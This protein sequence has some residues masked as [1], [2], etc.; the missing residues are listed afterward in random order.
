MA[1]VPALFAAV[2]AAEGDVVLD[3][4]SGTALSVSAV[5][6][7]ETL[8]LASAS[9]SGIASISGLDQRRWLRASHT[10]TP[11]PQQGAP[12]APLPGSDAARGS[13]TSSAG[14]GSG[15]LAISIHNGDDQMEQ[16]AS[17]A[18]EYRALSGQSIDL[19]GFRSIRLLGNGGYQNYKAYAW[20]TATI[21]SAAGSAEFFFPN[22]WIGYGELEVDLW[23]GSGGP[24]DP[25][26]IYSIS[27]SA[28]GANI[29]YSA[30]DFNGAGG[31]FFNYTMSSIQL[32][33]PTPAALAVLGAAAFASRSRHR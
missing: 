3:D 8:S 32:I 1:A 15:S 5:G 21:V 27:L 29:G 18:L 16:T 23:N 28:H 24:L 22:G 4:F 2:G 30:A 9:Q 33:V 13:G 31:V 25:G 7:D 19:S 10:L 12:W 17:A 6:A 14:G 26:A 20:F 11:H